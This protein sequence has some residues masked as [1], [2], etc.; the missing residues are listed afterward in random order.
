MSLGVHVLRANIASWLI[1]LALTISL[2]S[3]NR[4]ESPAAAGAVPTT[5][6]SPEAAGK[7]VLKRRDPGAPHRPR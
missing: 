6:A 7:A 5:F 1:L 2:A 4:S 3:C